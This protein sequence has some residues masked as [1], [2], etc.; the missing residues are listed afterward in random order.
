MV[1][2]GED[3]KKFRLTGKLFIILII[4]FLLQQKSLA[5]EGWQLIYSFTD[6]ISSICFIDRD[7]GYAST[8]FLSSSPA[9][10]KT[11]DGGYG[12][13]NLLATDKPINSI[14]FLNHDIGF[15]SGNSG[16]LYKTTNS[17]NSWDLI[18]TQETE[19]LGNIFF[20]DELNGWICLYDKI[21]KTTDGGINWSGSPTQGSIANMDVAFI[22]NSIGYAVGVYARMFKSTDGG[23]SWNQVTE[24]MVASMFGIKFLNDSTGFIV[25]GSEIVKT[26]DEGK[27]WNTVYNSDGSQLNLIQTFGS[28][29]AWVIA[30]NKILY[31]SDAGENWV[32]QS[33]TPYSYLSRGSCVDSLN[34]WALG[35]H[36]L[37]RT[38]NGGFTDVEAQNNFSP[39]T[40]CLS[41]NYPNPFNPTTNIGFQIA[42]FRFVSLKVYD[43]LGRE[44]A[45][46]I[47]EE[48]PAGNYEVKFDGSGLSS[49]IY[50]YKLSVSALPGQKG[51]A[52]N[53]TFVKKMILMK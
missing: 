42:E 51:Q 32:P 49:G 6:D 40:Y 8:S 31:T 43:M 14:Y 25:G 53:Y 5:Q 21:L 18:P 7:I 37:Y 36:K 29:F 39:E 34:A 16:T 48:K 10:L 24:P 1:L 11:T 26:T 45:T 15:A 41:Q 4:S 35:D 44:V 2:D 30:S 12:W 13:N 17:G 28:R 46:L 33:F 52:E 9:I 19:D 50:F 3:M 27:T 22:N 23:T 38:S 20:I 47:N